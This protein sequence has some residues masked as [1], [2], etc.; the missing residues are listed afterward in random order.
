MGTI[1]G[2]T[3]TTEGRFSPL[4]A[5][6]LPNTICRHLGSITVSS[7]DFMS[8]ELVDPLTFPSSSFSTCLRGEGLYPSFS[9]VKT[10]RV[11]CR[12]GEEL[13]NLCPFETPASE[14]LPFPI[15]RFAPVFVMKSKPIKPSAL[16]GSEHKIDA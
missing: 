7:T 6:S 2:S 14:I 4:V 8:H 13:T 5:S 10:V 11:A 9:G 15:S 3:H 1:A 12:E 16:V